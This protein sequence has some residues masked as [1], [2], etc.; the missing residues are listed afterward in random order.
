MNA[1][2][3]MSAERVRA[4]DLRQPDEVARIEGF[5]AQAA[6]SVFHRPAWLQAIERGTRQRARGLVAE[7]GGAITGWLPLTEVHSPIFGRMLASSGFAVDGGVLA[8]REAV[9]ERRQGDLTVSASIDQVHSGQIAATGEGLVLPVRA[10]GSATI[11][12]QPRR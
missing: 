2:F 12:Y 7:K 9:R 8:P 10:T 1:P 3:A 4:A 6:G 11:R 5:V